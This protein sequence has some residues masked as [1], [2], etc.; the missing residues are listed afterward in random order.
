MGGAAGFSVAG[1]RT[2][3]VF[4]SSVALAD[5]NGDRTPD[6]LV[7]AVHCG[8]EAPGCVYVVFTPAGVAPLPSV[9]VDGPGAAALALLNAS[10]YP[11][12][13]FGSA[14]SPAGDVDGDGIDDAALGAPFEGSG[15]GG[16]VYVVY[17]RRGPWPRVVGAD[18]IGSADLPGFA[19]RGGRMA[20][21]GFSV[22]AAGDLNGDGLGDVLFGGPGLQAI[23]G[24]P[25]AACV[26]WG[27]RHRSASAIVEYIDEGNG[28]CW[29]GSPPALGRSVST[30][31]FNGDR[32]ADQMALTLA[33]GTAIVWY[34]GAGTSSPSFQLAL[35]ASDPRLRVFVG[36]IGDINGDGADELAAGSHVVLG[37]RDQRAGR[38][39]LAAMTP[40]VGFTLAGA[41][42]FHVGASAARAGDVNGDR[43]DDFVV[44]AVRGDGRSEVFVLFGNRSSGGVWA[45]MDLG[46]LRCSQ[47]FRLRCQA[48]GS[49]PSLAAG[50][51]NGDGLSDVVVSQE[52]SPPSPSGESGR[53][54]V[55]LGVGRPVLSSNNFTLARG[56]PTLLSR[57]H[58]DFDT[59]AEPSDV[60]VRV[61]N[62]QAGFF[63]LAR[64]PSG[65]AERVTQ[66]SLADV[67]DSGV[68][69]VHD[70][71]A[72]TP[73]FSI[74]VMA[75]RAGCTWSLPVRAN[76]HLLTDAR[77]QSS[78]DIPVPRLCSALVEMHGKELKAFQ[79][80]FPQYYQM[81]HEDYT[82][83]RIKQN[84]L[85]II[86]IVTAAWEVRNPTLEAWYERRREYMGKELG[87]T[88]DEM[89]ERVAF[90]GT[91]EGNIGAICD[92]GL[93]RVGH[94]LNPSR[95]TD[96]GFFGDP[97][98]GVY[99]SRFVEYA[100]QYSNVGVTSAGAESPMC[101]LEGDKVRIIMFKALP[102]RT[103]HM[104]S[105]VGAVGPT[106]GYDSHSSPQWSEWFFF[107]ETQ[108]CP[109]HVVEV[110]AITNA[111]TEANEGL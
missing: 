94:P 64:A 36:S 65:K 82:E 104:E 81:H 54:H 66:F 88:E 79:R 107:D 25:G 31:D 32:V 4:G 5:L 90:H 35:D 106:A 44:G 51:I 46:H 67:N 72:T 2:A 101:L 85:P 42:L 70:G 57:S 100:L 58:L 30:G 20:L 6:L 11:S 74:S 93:L 12:G 99:A 96:A 40:D 105:F 43:V 92:N 1:P 29:V 110:K 83:K 77:E 84:K 10:G 50:D 33:N 71:S 7:G 56:R 23:A 53:V 78:S 22:A 69:F 24:Q 111:R 47:G 19:Y 60:F 48:N 39:S 41:D 75:R 76:V 109:T 61:G 9:A 18:R 68:A 27:S 49:L 80:S 37:S 15:L 86:F 59:L 108:L 13:L 21:A 17:G 73:S 55:L 87:R 91:K 16:S 26:L 102:G 97:H 34:G 103:L 14:L 8:H 63:A 52:F 95:S 62:A 89:E 98:Y 28:K 3:G 38:L 45:D